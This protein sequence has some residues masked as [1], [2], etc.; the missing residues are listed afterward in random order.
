MNNNEKKYIESILSEYKILEIYFGTD[1]NGNIAYDEEKD[2]LLSMKHIKNGNSYIGY[3]GFM[4]L[5][6]NKPKQY[7]EQQLQ[8]LEKNSNNVITPSEEQLLIV[9]NI[10]KNKN[11][12]VEAVAGSGKTTTV[13]F[14][15]EAM[16]KSKICQITYNKQLK[17]EVREKVVERKIKNLH[18]NT[19]HSLAVKFYNEHAH[20]DIELQQIIKKNTKPKFTEQID[21]II[22]DEVQDMTPDYYNFIL[23]FTH[24]MNFDGLIIILGDRYQGIYEFKNADSRFL[25]MGE[26]LYGEKNFTTL[27]LQESFRL[28]NHIAWFVNHAMLGYNRIVSNKK[29]KHLVYYLKRNVFSAHVELAKIIHT[30]IIQGYKASD[31]FVLAPSLKSSSNN[32]AKKLENELSAKNIPVFFSRN[33]NDGID[34]E[35]IKG[36]IVFTTFHQAKGRERKIVFVFGFDESYF[37]YHARDKDPNV[38]PSELYVAVTR[39]SEILYVIENDAENPLPFIKFSHNEMLTLPQI[40][41][42]IKF[43]GKVRLNKNKTTN[44]SD[45]N[46][47][48]VTVTELVAYLGQENI[49]RIYT[50]MKKIIATLKKPTIENTVEIPLTIE[51]NIGFTEIVS[52]LN[53]LVIPAYY[54]SRTSITGTSAL[55]DNLKYMY[56]TSSD[57]TREFIDIQLKKI[58]KQFKNNEFGRYLCNGNLFI[59]LTEGIHSNLQQIDKYDWLTKPIM[60]TCCKN[61][62]TNIKENP[63]Y[64]KT[65][66]NK[67]SE[68]ERFFRH[69][70]DLY[71]IVNIFGRVD[72]YDDDTLWEFKCVTSLQ[73]EHILQLVVYAWIWEN[74]MTDKHGAKKYNILNI[75][76][77]EKKQ[78]VY[79]NEIIDEIMNVLF[80]NKFGK[81]PKITNDEFVS[82]C[83]EIF[84]NVTN[85][86]VDESSVQ[87]NSDD[88]INMFIKPKKKV[89]TSDVSESNNSDNET[90][91][92]LKPKKKKSVKIKQIN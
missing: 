28:T 9:K 43:T 47:H 68:Q 15:A 73:M 59:T 75:R 10:K 84:T 83:S 42:H 8:G 6:E 3:D 74:S 40:N 18:I 31:I 52:N 30:Y 80:E 51:S 85:N 88:S 44:Q 4:D 67:G 65:I 62:G 49:G 35:V 33:D 20:D 87:E 53:G 19:Y 48:T 56:D 17:F 32:P 34:D 63:K 12:V 61:L 64:E 50:L 69:K 1:S 55:E 54:E 41:K 26:Q 7:Y 57:R 71:G 81:K 78:I 5:I 36:K 39:S 58:K 11:I 86:T 92:F 27:P 13:L 46:E 21:V 79:K 45:T 77:G 90:N 2:K 23:K 70:S 91:M 60:D 22:I 66:G 25:T 89:S 76:T 29:G 72:C 14:V 24:D 82:N 37:K 16:P 38:C